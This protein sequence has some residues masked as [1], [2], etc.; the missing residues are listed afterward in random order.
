MSFRTPGKKQL[1]LGL[2][3]LSVFCPGCKVS[4][5]AIAASQQMTA[6]AAELNEYYKALDQSATETIALY[7]LDG[8]ISGVPFSDA[9]RQGPD[10]AR[11]ELRNASRWRLL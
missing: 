8:A 4:D 1:I 5:D 2:L 3:G 7:E 11:L 9:D 6:T 10:T